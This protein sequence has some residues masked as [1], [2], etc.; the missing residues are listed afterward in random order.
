[1]VK[2]VCGILSTI[3]FLFLF[4]IAG[5]LFVPKFLGYSQYAVLSG[6]M[7]PDIH[8]GAIV[9]NKDFSEDAIEEGTVITYQLS[10]KTLITHRIVSIDRESRTVIT[11]GDANDSAFRFW[12]I[13]PCMQK[14]R[15]ELLQS[16]SY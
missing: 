2:K 5:L 7:E 15:L 8:V 14:P 6:S 16:V 4:V 3:V 9:Y 12:V 11:Q 1:M 10:E 13:S